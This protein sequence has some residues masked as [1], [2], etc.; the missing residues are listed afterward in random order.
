V[1]IYYSQNAI[2]IE[3]NPIPFVAGT[4]T[5]SLN[6][7]TGNVEICRIDSS[8]ILAATPWQS[9][10][11]ATGNTFGTSDEVM[12]YLDGEFTKRRPIGTLI[13]PYP[14]TGAASFSVDHGLAYVPRTTVVTADGAEVDTDVVH[15]PGRTT[16]TFASPFTGTLYLG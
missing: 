6:T 16:L 11:D 15:A 7:A 4:L 13:T 8:F 9:I 3:D 2:L 12:A 1:R 14:L 5:A 10:A